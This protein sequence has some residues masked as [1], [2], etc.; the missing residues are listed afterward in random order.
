MISRVE[1]FVIAE[2][3]PECHNQDAQ[4]GILIHRPR[5]GE[6]IVIPHEDAEEVAYQIL[7]LKR[8]PA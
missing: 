2:Y 8:R 6:A 7:R 1:G 4:P 3:I 5:P